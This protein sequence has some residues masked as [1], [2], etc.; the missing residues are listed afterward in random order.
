MCESFIARV[1]SLV[2]L[3][4]SAFFVG[5]SLAAADAVAPVGNNEE[6]GQA[7]DIGH[8][9]T[10][11][12]RTLRPG[13]WTVGSYAVVYG[14][15][16]SIFIATSPWIWLNYN[17]AN[18]HLKWAPRTEGPNRFGIFASY[19]ES[20]QKAFVG[21][22]PYFWKSASLHLLASRRWDPDLETFLSLRSSYFWNDDRPYSIRMD[23][24]ADSIRGQFDIT[25]LTRLTLEN[26]SFLLGFEFGTVGV[27]YIYPY[28][29]LGTSVSYIHG[30][31]L[32]QAGFSYTIQWRELHDSKGLRP[33]RIDSRIRKSPYDG[34]NYFFPYE[35]A[36]H[37]EMQ[38]QYFF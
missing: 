8:N 22:A 34:Q 6:Q 14:P 5:A 21:E 32:V 12:T 29:H 28:L 7:V 4:A 2:A 23:S 16:E 36:L 38:L 9:M 3:A 25:T 35:T 26:R 37:P 10:P 20:L 31:W 11:T 27:N 17:S 13:G 30:P 15:S 33:G 19:F 24:G 1:L 18:L